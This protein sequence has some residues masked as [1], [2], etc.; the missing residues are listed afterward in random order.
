ML[1]AHSI[2]ALNRARM[3]CES[4]GGGAENDDQDQDQT[5]HFYEVCGEFLKSLYVTSGFNADRLAS[6]P[7]L[8]IRATPNF[9]SSL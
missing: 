1:P 3:P 7:C 5:P 9:V 2:A 4:R 8:I 6:D